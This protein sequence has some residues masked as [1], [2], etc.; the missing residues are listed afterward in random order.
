MPRNQKLAP[1]LHGRVVASV[2][3]PALTATPP[4]SPFAPSPAA[5]WHVH[6]ADGSILAVRTDGTAPSGVDHAAG[7]SLVD[8]TQHGTELTLTLGPAAPSA[9]AAAASALSA[10]PHVAAAAP[11]SATLVFHTAEPAGC[12]MLRDGKG[13]MEYA[14]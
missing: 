8:V 6:L 13:A 12:V 1:L 9:N 10:A 7:A 2:E 3:P 5:T 4:A 11:A 14:D